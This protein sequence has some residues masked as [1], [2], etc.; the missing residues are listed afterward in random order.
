[1]T[2]YPA[3][4]WFGEESS[5]HLLPQTTGRCSSS[6]DRTAEAR[7]APA[8]LEEQLNKV[9]H[10]RSLPIHSLPSLVRALSFR[11]AIYDGCSNSQSPIQAPGEGKAETSQ[12]PAQQFFPLWLLG[13]DWAKR[14]GLPWLLMLLSWGCHNKIPYA[15]GLKSQK[16]IVSQV[17]RLEVLHQCFGSAMLPLK[18]EGKS[19]LASS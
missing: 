2:V 6:P 18:P 9:S 13:Q 8:R 11:L 10:P 15:G 12:N 3:G 16:C 17:S 7:L 19:L 5:L 1:M 4:H 14:V